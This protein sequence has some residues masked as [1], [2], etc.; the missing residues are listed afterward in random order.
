VQELAEGGKPG[1]GIGQDEV[2]VVGEDTE[3]VELDAEAVRG[4]GEQVAQGGVGELGGPEEKLALDA[5]AGDEVG[6]A[7]KDLSRNQSR[8]R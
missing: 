6:G 2:E 8:H 7:W 5:T 1:V 4:Q 3:S